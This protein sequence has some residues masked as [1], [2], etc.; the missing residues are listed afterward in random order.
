MHI[1]LCLNWICIP[2]AR[3]VLPNVGPNWD[4][5]SLALC[6]SCGVLGGLYDWMSSFLTLMGSLV[7][8]FFSWLS[9]LLPNLVR[10]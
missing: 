2:Q 6:N 4:A 5:N 1:I 7:V 3:K 8:L 10:N 9:N